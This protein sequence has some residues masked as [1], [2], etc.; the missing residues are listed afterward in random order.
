M[1]YSRKN[2]GNGLICEQVGKESLN[3]TVGQRPSECL[4]ALHLH[5]RLSL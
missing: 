4:N 5:Y 3:Y 2:I 1:E